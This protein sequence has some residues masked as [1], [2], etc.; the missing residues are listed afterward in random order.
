MALMTVEKRVRREREN[1]V[2]KKKH[3]LLLG[4]E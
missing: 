1:V 4:M 3:R 2:R